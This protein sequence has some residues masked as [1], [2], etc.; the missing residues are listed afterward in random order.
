MTGIF[1]GF[2]DIIF[3][4]RLIAILLT[5][6]LLTVDCPMRLRTRVRYTGNAAI[7]LKLPW[8][9]RKAPRDRWPGGLIIVRDSSEGQTAET[10]EW[11]VLELE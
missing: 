2:C 3:K 5:L 1:R 11:D 9:Y 6:I 7:F 10:T 8:A 4:P